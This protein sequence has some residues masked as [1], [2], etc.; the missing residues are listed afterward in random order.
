MDLEIVHMTEDDVRAELAERGHCYDTIARAGLAF[1]ETLLEPYR[2]I[3][4]IRAR[5]FLCPRAAPHVE[6]RRGIV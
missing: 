1:M 5:G 3:A 2:L 6:H 4:H